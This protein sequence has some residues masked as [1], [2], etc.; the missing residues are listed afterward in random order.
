MTKTYDIIHLPD[1]YMYAVDNKKIPYNPNGGTNGLFICLSEINMGH[2]EDAFVKNVGN[3]EGCRTI[4]TTNN[5]TLGLLLLPEIEE[6]MSNPILIRI[7]AEIARKE[8]TKDEASVYY[9]NGLR[10]CLSWVKQSLKLD[11]RYTKE[12]LLKACELAGRRAANAKNY[13]DFHMKEE[14]LPYLQSLSPKPMAIEIEMWSP[15]T[16]EQGYFT[17]LG[18]KE[19]TLDKNNFVQVKQWIYE[20]K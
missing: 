13:S 10:N 11:K 16:D 12:E 3:C 8:D 4:I 1:G 20:K 7:K 15:T 19:P 2:P 14:V 18:Y 17:P 6:D 9:V 5:P